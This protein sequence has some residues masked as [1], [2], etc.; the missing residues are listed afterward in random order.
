M[1]AATEQAVVAELVAAA[2]AEASAVPAEVLVQE[3][4]VV[5]AVEQVQG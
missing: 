1:V 3:P 4:A 2:Q 5:V